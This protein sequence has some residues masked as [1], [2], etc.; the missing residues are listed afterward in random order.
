MSSGLD[1]A[2]SAGRGTARQADL[3]GQFHGPQRP[4]DAVVLQIGRDDVIAFLAARP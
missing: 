3:A 2:V 1:G 4:A